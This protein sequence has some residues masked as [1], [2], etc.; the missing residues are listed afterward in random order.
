MQTRH[1]NR[2]QYFEEQAYTTTNHVIPFISNYR[3]IEPGMRVLEVGCGEGGNLKPFLEIGCKT[4]GIDLACNKIELARSFFAAH[5]HKENLTLICNDIY[6]TD[7]PDSGFDLIIMRDVIEHIHNQ[8]LFMSFIKSFLREGGLFFLAFPPWQNPFG[9]HQQVCR[10]RILSRLPYFHLLPQ[11]LY[12]LLLKLGGESNGTIESLLEVR[13]TRLSVERFMRIVKETGYQVI[14][15]RFYF[16]NPNYEVKFNLKPVRQA[17]LV[18]AIPVLR[19]F[20]TTSVYCLITPS[21]SEM[22]HQSDQ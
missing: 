12:R 22:H 17:S 5:P 10:N 14:S 7:P 13:E 8:Q 4:T 18:S 3:N 21:V 20:V 11:W 6:K 15:R 2:I 9:G 19:N 1:R 16:I